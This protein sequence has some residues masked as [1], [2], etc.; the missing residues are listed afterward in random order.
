MIGLKKEHKF[1]FWGA[2]R[3]EQYPGEY[4]EGR[5]G[6]R[7]LRMEKV[8]TIWKMTCTAAGIAG[9]IIAQAMGGWDSAM[10]TLMI[11]MAI[12]YA[13]GLIVAG[14]FHASPKSE[15]GALESR[16]GLKGLI[17]KGYMLLFVL[18]G[19]RLDMA[20]GIGFVRDGVIIGFLM[21]EVVSIVENAG[22]M[23]VPLPAAVQEAIELL[24]K[25]EGEKHDAA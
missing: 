25:K 20:L 5:R 24:K 18:I 23:G 19:A 21:N 7:I 10:A 11:F 12:D 4:Y 8:R 14:I 16:A 3:I 13:T 2:G 15:S 9:G 1:F 6:G 22:L 17:R